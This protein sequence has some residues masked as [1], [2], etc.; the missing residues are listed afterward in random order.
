MGLRVSVRPLARAAESAPRSE[1]QRR[2]SC[3]CPRAAASLKGRP[4]RRRPVTSVRGATV[5]CN[6]AGPSRY[7]QPSPSRHCASGLR[8]VHP[9]LVDHSHWQSPRPDLVPQRP[10][11]LSA[12]FWLRSTSIRSGWHDDGTQERKLDLGGLQS[13]ASF[14]PP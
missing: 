13:R 11:A 4:R 8:L 2:S 14:C 3:R 12:V 9:S 1:H 7:A 10:A 5:V 6:W